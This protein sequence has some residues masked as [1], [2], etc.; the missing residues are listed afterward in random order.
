MKASYKHAVLLTT[1]NGNSVMVAPLQVLKEMSLKVPKNEFQVI[2]RKS[3]NKQVNKKLS[4]FT[5]DMN[6][7]KFV[8]VK[9]YQTVAHRYVLDN[10]RILLFL[11]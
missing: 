5:I 3:G 7:Q 9:D 1:S 6:K 10:S 11:S 4:D 2:S 8:R